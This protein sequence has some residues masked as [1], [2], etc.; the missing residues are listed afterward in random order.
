MKISNKT[1]S[2]NKALEYLFENYKP[3]D[4]KTSHLVNALPTLANQLYAYAQHRARVLAKTFRPSLPNSILTAMTKP[5][6]NRKNILALCIFDLELSQYFDEIFIY[7]DDKQL[8]SLLVD[9]LLY[10]ATGYESS[11]PTDSE[12]LAEGTHKARGIHKYFLAHQQS[13]HIGDIQSWVFGKEVA[14]INGKPNLI[15]VILAVSTFSIDVRYYAK[16]T[17]IFSLYGSLPSEAEQ[18]EFRASLEQKNKELM[19]KFNNI[20]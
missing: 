1:R 15:S 19:E 8:A 2:G 5:F 17:C 14:A 16:N 18:K 3:I 4:D 9:S 12:V 13:K 6:S 11:S 10:Q 20:S 7:C